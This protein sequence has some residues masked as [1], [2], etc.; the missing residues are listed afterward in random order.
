MAHNM[1]DSSARSDANC[2][3]IS[4]NHY[5]LVSHHDTIL[6]ADLSSKRIRHA[7][8][9]IAPWNLVL[10]LDEDRGRLMTMGVDA[11]QPRRQ[12]SFSEAGGEFRLIA[13][14]GPFDCQ[15][16]SFADDSIGILASGKYLAADWGGTAANDRDWCR[17]WE[18]FRLV[19]A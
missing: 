1:R 9:G 2:F 14:G 16:E 19:R 7:P 11:P 13:D 10:E 5:H 8:F 18:R 3:M 15:I 4:Q 12:V 6:Y 17:D